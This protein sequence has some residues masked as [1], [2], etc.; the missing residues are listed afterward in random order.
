MVKV[1]LVDD[2]PVVIRIYRDG[3]TRLG[4]EVAT[5]ADG[6]EALKSLRADRPDVM[7][8]DLMMP[9]L[10]GAEVLKFMRAERAWQTLPVLVLSNAYM[11]P[12]AQDAAL[13]GA[14]KGLLKVKC[15]P[16]S[17]AESIREVL[18]GQA[19]SE[20]I[21]QLLAASHAP[22]G[23]IAPSPATPPTPEP[24]APE[25]SRSQAPGSP[26]PTPQEPVSEP[27]TFSNELRESARQELATQGAAIGL[28]L[29]HSF[30]AFLAARGES[31]RGFRLQDFFRKVHFITA[32]G[33]MADHHHL[34]QMASALEALLYGL[35]DKPQVLEPSVDRT[36]A[37]AVDFLQQLLVSSQKPRP[38]ANPHP[39]ALVVD[40]DRLTNRLVVSALRNAQFQAQ[41]TESP[42]MA[43]E[44]MREKVYDLVLAD[45]EMPDMDGIELCK[46][47]RRIP[48]Y[49][50]VPV[51]FVTLHS[52]FATR[53]KTALSWTDLIAKPVRPAELAVKAVMHLLKSQLPG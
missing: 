12:L 44:L 4:F 9:K 20:N 37:M 8:L 21:D 32:M 35:M 6:L 24:S 26:G 28:G 43:L 3:L 33:G 2:D 10:S 34:A 27:Q 41:A 14:Q 5:A 46:Q 39:L 22:P 53:A 30:Q 18:G 40:D 50:R 45:I 23:D 47:L 19:S 13:L 48:G 52:D 16:A 51:I 38:V 17:L 29:V 7:V 49:E 31:E 11:D 15:N 36:T 42:V 25:V 1:L